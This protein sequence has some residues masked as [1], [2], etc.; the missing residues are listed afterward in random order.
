M[1]CKI[2]IR[3]EEM[4]ARS[5]KAYILYHGPGLLPCEKGACFEDKKVGEKEIN[6]VGCR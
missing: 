2:K 3:Y 1:L 5:P 4:K 6:V